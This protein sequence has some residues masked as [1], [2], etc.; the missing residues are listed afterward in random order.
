[1]PKLIYVV[2]DCQ[3]ILVGAYSNKKAAYNSSISYIKESYY[4][5]ESRT[6]KI[7]KSYSQLCKEFI[8]YN[9][10]DISIEGKENHFSVQVV[11]M[12]LGSKF[13]G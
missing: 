13:N 3:G 12:A 4:F 7:T 5:E 1:M 6:K 9:S 8:K 2:K 11:E 10:C